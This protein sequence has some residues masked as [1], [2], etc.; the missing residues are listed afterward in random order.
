LADEAETIVHG[1]IIST[2]AEP[3][4]Q[5]KNLMTVVVT[6]SIADTY[7]GARRSSLVFRQYA[8]DAV[9]YH[10]LNDYRKGQEIVLFLRPVSEYGLTSPAGLEQGR[11]NV[12]TDHRTG[13]K[14]AVN[15]RGNVGLFDNFEEH[16]AARN[17]QLS[18]LLK[19]IVKAHTSGPVQLKDLE[20]M[21]NELARVR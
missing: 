20:S 15:G 13:Q 3:H 19:N 5:L 4:P 17:L 16:A 9:Q 7:K 11:F 18:P 10:S 14:I 8:V 12:L 1:Y 6:M 21:I 2:R